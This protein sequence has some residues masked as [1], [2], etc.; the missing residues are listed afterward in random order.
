M[1]SPATSLQISVAEDF[2]RA[3]GARCPEDGPDS[4]EEFRVRVLIPLF[5]EA[6]QQ[7]VS[8]TVNL[9]G[10]YG[11]ATSFLQGT[12]GNLAAEYGSSAVKGTVRVISDD[13]P[14]LHEYIE[15]YIDEANLVE[16]EQKVE[17][18]KAAT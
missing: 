17:A 6:R 14:Y 11:Y 3:P 12:F 9:D 10:V 13:D 4:A 8:L 15:R 5:E 7:G 1:K 16:C 18:H 2:S